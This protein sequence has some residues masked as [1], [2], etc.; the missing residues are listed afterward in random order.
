MILEK[1]IRFFL[2]ILVVSFMAR[3][4]GVEM[5]GQLNFAIAVLSI[6]T[7]VASA[8]MNRIV[9]RETVSAIGDEAKKSEVVST[10]FFIRLVFSAA[11]FLILFFYISLLYEG[12][13]AA[14][15]VVL[16]SILLNPFDVVD[17]HQQGVAQVK[18]ISLIRSIVFV[19]ISLLKILFV[20]YQASYFYFFL[21]VL[22]EHFLVATLIYLYA[23]LQYGVSFISTSRFS[24]VRALS[25]LTE[26]WPEILAGASAILF[27]RLDQVM[28]KFVVGEESVGVYSAAVR[29]SE[30][31]YFLPAAIVAASFP[32]IVQLKDGWPDKYLD[33]VL[34]LFS[35]LVFMT[36]SAATFFIATSDFIIFLIYGDGFKESSL[37]LKI[38][39]ITA[40]FV[41]LGAASGSWLAAEKK[42]M[43]NFHRTLFGLM[44]NVVLNLILI[45][46]YGAAGAAIATLMAVIS[47]FYLFDLLSNRL[48]FMFYLKSKAI[49]SLGFYGLYLF[50]KNKKSLGSI[51]PSL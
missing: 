45:E 22:V 33:A 10:V 12:N 19:V 28:L 46:R 29:I 17:L 51:T 35:I 50:I 27:M 13:Q 32:K 5:F 9:I 34:V 2:G 4:L 26:S 23:Y 25:F 37:V 8:G 38:H 41:F 11:I 16:L 30:A 18:K 20:V 6:F 31:W 14:L 44:V 1:S 48:R 49:F 15:L 7:V 3:Y 40:V 39:C 36:I 24:K 43:W 21:F 47:A 42:L